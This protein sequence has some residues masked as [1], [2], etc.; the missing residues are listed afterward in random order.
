MS[1]WKFLEPLRRGFRA[2]RIWKAVASL[3]FLIWW[4]ARTWSYPGGCTNEKQQQR[5]SRPA[6]HRGGVAPAPQQHQNQKQKVEAIPE[7]ARTREPTAS[8][9][10]WEPLC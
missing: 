6:P 4:D 9:T 8:R 1:Y 5:Q 2:L 7:S 10:S 3:L